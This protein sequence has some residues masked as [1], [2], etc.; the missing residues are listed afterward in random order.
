MSAPIM[1]SV[2][3]KYNSYVNYMS[4]INT[5]HLTNMADKYTSAI[6]GARDVINSR[7]SALLANEKIGGSVCHC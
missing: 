5:D 3:D 1:A 7:A 4:Q 2:N 6:Y